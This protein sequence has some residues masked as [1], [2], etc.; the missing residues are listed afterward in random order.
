MARFM[1]F[2]ETTNPLFSPFEAFCRVERVIGFLDL[3]EHG[4][5][6]GLILGVPTAVP[7]IGDVSNIAEKVLNTNLFRFL[8][9]YY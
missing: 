7:L 5:I 2:K 9:L 4:R 6:L 3:F 8:R 1:Q